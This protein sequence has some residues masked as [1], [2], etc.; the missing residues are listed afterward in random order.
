[1]KRFVIAVFSHETNT[2][3]SIPTPLKSFGLFTGGNGPVLGDEALKAY[4]GT[5]TPV[6]A[7]IDFR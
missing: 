1:M 6:A 3:S 7:F 5:N 2:F 4:Q